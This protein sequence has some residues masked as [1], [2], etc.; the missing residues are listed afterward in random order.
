MYSH[1]VPMFTPRVLRPTRAR[2]SLS[3]SITFYTDVGC[4]KGKK[5]TRFQ[6]GSERRWEGEYKWSDVRLASCLLTWLERSDKTLKGEDS[7]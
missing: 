3:S 2:N 4:A 5:V 7:I 6:C 1:S